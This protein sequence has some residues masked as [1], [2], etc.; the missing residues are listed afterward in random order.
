V[1]FIE[2]TLLAVG[3][4]LD[5]FSVSI[6]K[7]L[8]MERISWRTTL[9]IACAFGLFQA[10]MPLIGWALGSRLLWLIAPID[11]WI[12]FGLLAFI[13]YGMICDALSKDDEVERGS[14][15]R[16]PL[17]ELLVLSVAT[18]IGALASGIA[19]ASLS[20]D[21]V[22]AVALIGITTFALS[23][24]GVLIGHRFGAVHR[25]FATLAGGIILILIG[26]K[27]LLEHLGVLVL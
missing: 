2:L 25:R 23:V 5:A 8:G 12:A 27:V 26:T 21:I 1:S 17:R 6:C 15:T 16:V 11:H 7:G 22:A 9:M 14:V 10:G 20:I 24:A 19:L 4:S 3:L 18:S 13:G